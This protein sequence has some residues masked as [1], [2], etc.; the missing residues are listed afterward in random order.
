MSL[1]ITSFD[2]RYVFRFLA[3]HQEKVALALE[4]DG[5]DVSNVRQSQTQMR[6]QGGDLTILSNGFL[7]DERAQRAMRYN[8][9]SSH[10][11]PPVT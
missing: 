5:K 4:A 6:E 7:R 11:R 2:K 9:V 8:Y 10:R 1:G 3:R